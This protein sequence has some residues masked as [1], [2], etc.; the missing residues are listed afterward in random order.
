MSKSFVRHR[1]FGA[2]IGGGTAGFGAAAAAACCGGQGLGCEPAVQTEGGAA[3]PAGCVR[4]TGRAALYSS[5]GDWMQDLTFYDGETLTM[6][7]PPGDYYSSARTVRRSAFVWRKCLVAYWWAAMDGQMGRSCIW[8]MSR[9]A[10][11]R[12]FA[13]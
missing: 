2:G 9:A 4:G 12:W 8:K 7:M 3:T 5:Q 10:A 13:G 11:S 6:A 1:L